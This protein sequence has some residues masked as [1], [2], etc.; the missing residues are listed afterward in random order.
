MVIVLI[1]TLVLLDIF[2][3]FIHPDSFLFIL[4]GDILKLYV[5]EIFLGFFL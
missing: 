3:L 4:I 2:V 1:I 5:P